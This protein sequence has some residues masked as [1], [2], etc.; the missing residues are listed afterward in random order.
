[1]LG[2]LR[3]LKDAKKVNKIVLA[4]PNTKEDKILLEIGKENQISVYQ[5]SENNLLERYFKAAVMKSANFVV[6]LPADNA[7]PEPIEIDKIIS[8]HLSLNRRGFSS[9]LSSFFNS[10]YPDGIEQKFLTFHF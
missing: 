5:G 3:E 9:N 8:H 7:V 4:V 6:R 10:G 1:M 2:L